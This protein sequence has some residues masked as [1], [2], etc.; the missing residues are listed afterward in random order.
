MT[1][2]DNWLRID[3]AAMAR[4]VQCCDCFR[5][6]MVSLICRRDGIVWLDPEYADEHF[7]PSSQWQERQERWIGIMAA[8]PR[9]WEPFWVSKP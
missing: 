6:G 5:E 9:T 1:I 2:P 3:N 8:Q 4:N 7:E